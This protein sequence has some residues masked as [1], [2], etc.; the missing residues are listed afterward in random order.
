MGRPDDEHQRLQSL[1]ATGLLNTPSEARF[2]RY[3]RIATRLFDVPVALISLVD[4]DR[5]WF[6]S[7]AGTTRTEMSRRGSF[8]THA[9]LADAPLVVENAL[10]DD[11]FCDN[12]QVRQAPGYRFYAGVPLH[13]ESGHRIGTLCLLDDRP[14]D[15]AEENRQQLIELAGCV[16]DEL[17]RSA[18]SHF[19]SV[20]ERLVLIQTQNLDDPG[21][22]IR[23]GVRL[24]C[25]YL[26]LPIGIV[27]RID[28]DSYTVLT[29]VS[30]EDALVD[31]QTFSLGQTYCSILLRQPDVLSIEHMGESEYAGHPC[32]QAFGLE[33]YI[34][35]PLTVQGAPYGTLNF[36]SPYPRVPG[37]FSDMDRNLI[38][39]LASW[40]S[41]MLDHWQARESSLAG[42]RRFQHFFDMSPIGLIRN[43]YQTGRFLDVNEAFLRQTGYDRQTLLSLCNED[44]T[45]EETYREDQRRLATIPGDTQ[46]GP[47]EKTFIRA[48]GDHYPAMMHGV[49]M[50]EAGDREVVW[51]MVEDMTERHRLARMQRQ[52]VSTVSHELRTPL[53]SLNGILRLL[54]AGVTG[55]L[56]DRAT[57]LVQRAERNGERLAALIDDLLDMER[58]VAGRMSIHPEVVDVGRLVREAIDGNR[59]YA[60]RLNVTLAP[61]IEVDTAWVRVDRRRFDQILTNYLSNA[62][63][64]SG[65]SGVVDIDVCRSADGLVRIAVADRG[66]GVPAAFRPRLFEAFAQSDSSTKRSLPGTGLGL[67]ICREL[68]TLMGGDVG[69]EPRDGG[70]SVFYARFPEVGLNDS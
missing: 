24:G 63:K 50:R 67:S 33:S 60:D 45:P 41:A 44:I 4:T 54:G 8:C 23:Q 26:G 5:L 65:D 19:E 28:G 43:D 30:P 15:F 52:F 49:V 39:R 58:L 14:R 25:E 55:A 42:E 7:A 35:A 53:T 47:Y 6:K 38:R 10:E 32:Y 16:D 34:G 64:F 12:P 40:V 21:E 3:T 17:K 56:P 51:S 37:G 29:Q 13:G 46:F 66:E 31:G 68:A 36:S 48:N 27:S 9:I 2:D 11:R 1:Y 70:G 18:A 61:R 57:D 69:Y 22:R 62:A 20:M 59:P